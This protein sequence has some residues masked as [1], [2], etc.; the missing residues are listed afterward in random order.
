ME[1]EIEGERESYLSSFVEAALSRA[2]PVSWSIQVRVGN[3]PSQ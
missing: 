1:R 2:A 3:L